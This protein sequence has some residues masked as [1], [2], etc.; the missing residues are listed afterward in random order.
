MIPVLISV[1]LSPVI[2]G[3]WIM[4]DQMI[5][6]DSFVFNEGR[7]VFELDSI[8]S[9]MH[10]NGF[11]VMK[12]DDLFGGSTAKIVLNFTKD[13][14]EF[15]L[16]GIWKPYF[17]ER[18]TTQSRI[19]WNPNELIA[20]HLDLYLGL[21][22]TP[23]TIY[24]P[25]PKHLLCSHLFHHSETS[26]RFLHRGI[27]CSDPNL[28]SSI[29]GF[30]QIIISP[31]QYV[32]YRSILSPEVES[33]LST[34]LTTKWSLNTCREYNQ[35]ML[36]DFLLGNA[37]RENN[38]FYVKK[39]ITIPTTPTTTPTTIA[40]TIAATIVKWSDVIRSHLWSKETSYVYLD[41]NIVMKN[42]SKVPFCLDARVGG[43]CNCKFRRQTI[44]TIKQGELGEIA[45]KSV[46][47]K[48]YWRSNEKEERERWIEMTK[49]A[50]LLLEFVED[51][52]NDF[53][54]DFVFEV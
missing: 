25:I 5:P 21:G 29:P 32:V 17:N 12:G 1:I 48:E 49:R 23:T 22:K 45:K 16:Q 39:Q 31:S 34:L 50:Q 52:I 19:E 51:C 54:E 4:Y 43:V 14:F 36:F 30:C 27:N 53:G 15:D 33:L 44:Q 10:S 47:D 38:R 11:N 13:E 46:E 7:E 2:V 20:F 24:L 28:P 6:N 41:H 8:W 42:S 37:D 9:R 35:R 40:T 18:N 26:N 3:I